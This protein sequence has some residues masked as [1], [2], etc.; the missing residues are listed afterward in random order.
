M[1]QRIW[2]FRYLGDD[3]AQDIKDKYGFDGDLADILVQ[4][5][6]RQ[7]LKWHHYIPLYD[8]YFRQFRGTPVRL[9]E[10][11]VAGGG[12]LMMWR[13]YFGEAATVFGVD[14][15]ESCRKFDGEG[16][17][18]RIGSQDDPQFLESVV[19]EMG[20]VDLVIDD[21][22]HQMPH[23]QASLDILFPLLNEQGVYL[24]E[25]MHT[26]YWP[27]FGGGIDSPANAFGRL[28]PL[29]DAMHRWYLLGEADYPEY[30]EWLSGIHIHD[31]VIVLEKKK[32]IPPT[33]SN[34]F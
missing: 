32:P 27:R 6:G 23:V 11:G 9:L 15:D 14:I 28:R 2:Q 31:S 24:I 1:S 8:R 5:S 26:A 17:R 22:S 30:A 20:G 25:D 21:G 7:T 13:R 16:A 18:V 12:S 29:I 19:S 33:H 34:I 3:A 10:I 4:P